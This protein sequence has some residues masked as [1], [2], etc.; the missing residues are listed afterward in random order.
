[1]SEET[2]IH[3]L[4]L[5]RKTNVL[6]THDDDDDHHHRRDHHDHDQHHDNDYRNHHNGH[7]HFDHHHHHRDGDD[8][9]YADDDHH[10]HHWLAGARALTSLFHKGILLIS[11]GRS[12]T[13]ISSFPQ[14][15]L[16]YVSWC[17]S[18]SLSCNESVSTI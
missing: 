10:H 11:D 18:L 8:D 16:V 4:K 9:N 6:I 2:Y 12:A 14:N 13:S 15:S 7:Y 3:V 1:M 5:Q 17:S